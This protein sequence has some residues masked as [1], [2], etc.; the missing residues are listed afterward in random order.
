MTL[1]RTFLIL[2]A[3]LVL[4]PPPSRADFKTE[5]ISNEKG[6]SNSSVNCLLTDSR[7]KLW[8][9]TWD[10]LNVYDGGSVITYKSN[11]VDPATISDNIIRS[12]K[13]QGDGTIWVATDYGINKRS[14]GE[15]GWSRFHLGYENKYPTNENVFSM[16]ISAGQTVFASAGGW[17]IAMYDPASGQ[18][19]PFNIRGLNTSAIRTF[20]CV[21]DDRLLILDT[22]DNLYEVEYSI[23]R[24]G[25]LTVGNNTLLYQDRGVRRIFKNGNELFVCLRDNSVTM[26]DSMTGAVTPLGH[27][28]AAGELVNALKWD[29]GL[30]IVSNTSSEIFACSL[31]DGRMCT[32]ERI[33]NSDVVTLCKSHDGILFVGTDGNGVLQIYDDIKQFHS[34]PLTAIS[35]RIRPVRSFYKDRGGNVYVGTK[36]NGMYII[37]PDGSSEN[38][39]D[40][41]GLSTNSVYAMAE[42]R[43]GNILIGHDGNG[44]EVY[45]PK[46]RTFSHIRPAGDEYFGAVYVIFIDPDDGSV[47]LGSFGDGLLRLGLEMRNGQ[48]AITRQERYTNRPDDTNSLSNNIISSILKDSEGFLWIGT[49]GG[50][51][52]RFNP[53]TK[54]F[55]HYTVTAEEGSISSNDILSLCMSRDSSLLIGTGFGFNK[56]SDLSGGD[57]VFESFT[58][59]D[60]L[61]NNTVHGI[62]EDDSGKLWL[63]TNKGL[64]MLDSGNSQYISFYNYDSLQDEYTDGACFRSHDGLIY[65][66]GHDGIDWFHPDSVKVRTYR[67]RPEISGIMVRSRPVSLQDT[68][69]TR[70]L[71][72]K[73]SDNFFVVNFSAV[74]YINNSNCRFEYNLQGF[75]DTWTDAGRGNSATFTNVPPGK[76]R[77]TVRCTNGDKVLSPYTQSLD[78]IIKNPWYDTILAR[79]CYCILAALMFWLFI[80]ILKKRMERKKKIEFDELKRQQEQA[81]YEAKLRFFTDI[82]HE[83]G[84][85]LTLICGS[86]E[87]LVSGGKMTAK[88][89]KYLSVIQNNANRM[90]RLIGELMEFRKVDTGNREPVFS[91]VCISDFVTSIIGNFSEMNDEKGISLNVSLPPEKLF[92]VSDRGALEKIIYNLVSNAYKYTHSYGRIDIGLS[93]REDGTH[94]VVRNYGKGLTPDELKRIFNRF[95]V[96]EN[97]EIQVAKGKPFRNGI[98]LNLALSLAKTLSGDIVPTSVLGEYTQFELVL[99]HIPEDRILLENTVENP[100]DSTIPSMPEMGQDYIETGYVPEPAP[101]HEPVR[102]DGERLT[103]MIVDDEESIRNLVSDIFS[104]AYTVLQADNGEAAVELLKNHRADLIITDLMMPRMNGIE[105]VRHLKSDELTRF[106]PIVFLT[107]KNNVETE[108]N[109]YEIGVEAFLPKPFYPK[110]LKA[111]VSRIL[112]NRQDLR[113]YY[114]SAI[115]KTTVLNGKAVKEEDRKF[116][117]QLTAVVE[118]NMTDESMSANFLCDKMHVSRMSL[119]RKLKD[120]AS[121]T[122]SEFIMNIKIGHAAQLLRTTSMTVQEIMYASGFNNKSYF[123]REFAERF[124][125]TPK[126]YRTA[127][128]RDRTEE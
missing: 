58:S 44:L 36:G 107:F 24:S 69:K 59:D 125:M 13:E 86:S 90:Q 98:G 67:P 103:L 9:G 35:Q 70:R 95:V 40:A 115:S 92:I 123:Y 25:R 113:Q 33:H 119:Y 63:S 60:I 38:I 7:G 77:L 127:G 53:R 3:A 56:L 20:F 62:I 18:M 8:I 71:V 41:D 78:I 124:Q 121:V 54:E 73:H 118:E 5:Y 105:F 57:A 117:V 85:P 39:T 96:L 66:G 83:F 80:Y 10:G 89:I 93:D 109:S 22:A 74:E 126:E 87:Q 2:L 120:I 76:Y 37:R 50:G 110:Q 101:V 47:W 64:A 81:T 97:F 104:P 31:P 88:E 21:G 68:V 28:G 108:I 26:I 12:V 112:R 46:T 15:S 99:P 75:D 61:P 52:N 42:D 102:D 84:T 23:D 82:A 114:N 55:D 48:Y 14:P 111:V 30:L 106:I 79:I 65:L 29:D 128:E 4:A 100:E 122:P 11:P 45:S 1:K 72:L 49:R 116:I 94:F 34:L 91:K 6:L 17:G 51:L 43:Y 32:V 27:I 16:D 19:I